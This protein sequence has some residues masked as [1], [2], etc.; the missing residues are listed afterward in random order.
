M[1]TRLIHASF[2]VASVLFAAPYAH[3]ETCDAAREQAGTLHEQNHLL[4]A[5][6]HYRACLSSC[7]SGSPADVEATKSCSEGLQRLEER[8][9]SVVLSATEANGQRLTDVS[10]VMDG[11][12]LTAKLDGSAIEVEP[13]SHAFVFTHA[14]TSKSLLFSANEGQ[15]EQ[16]VKVVFGSA[17][18]A[19]APVAAKSADLQHVSFTSEDSSAWELASSEGKLVC[20]LPCTADLDPD[21]G[22]QVRTKG[23]STRKTFLG[24]AAVGSSATVSPPRGSRGTAALTFIV[25]TVVAGAGTAI[26]FAGNTEECGYGKTTDENGNVDYPVK[27]KGRCSETAPPPGYYAGTGTDLGDTEKGNQKLGITMGAVGGAGMVAG[28]IWW[29]LSSSEPTIEWGR[30]VGSAAP[31]KLA[32]DVG[33]RA[34]GLRGTW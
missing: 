1:K 5:R 28:G 16:E 7:V 15:R 14:G 23:G 10:V 26:Y 13:G 32:F 21:K 9:P 31:R 8:I 17:V 11:R 3:A 12:S 22:Y 25:S 6:E 24:S 19:A 30:P 34:V 20:A 18:P 4:E 2:V 27:V 29:L 33:P